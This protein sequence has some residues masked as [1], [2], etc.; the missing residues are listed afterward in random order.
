MKMIR[1]LASTRIIF[2]VTFLLLVIS[3][4]GVTLGATPGPFALSE[5]SSGQNTAT[6][7]SG[8]YLEAKA[9]WEGVGRV[10]G[11]VPVS[12][13]VKNNGPAFKGRVEVVVSTRVLPYQVAVPVI[14]YG[15]EISLPPGGQKRV[16]QHVPLERMG[17]NGFLEVRL[18]KAGTEEVLAQV[19][20]ALKVYG[21]DTVLAGVLSER[22]DQVFEFLENIQLGKDQRG[23]PLYPRVLKISRELLPEQPGVFDTFSVLLV[24]GFDPSSL[25]QRQRESLLDW[26]E[27]GGV[28]VVTVGNR[29]DN[30]ADLL[31]LS[32]PPVTVTKTVT[33]L[34]VEEL[35]GYTLRE[36]HARPFTVAVLKGSTGEGVGKTTAGPVAWSTRVGRGVL[37]V[38]GIDPGVEPMLTW[39]HKEDFWRGLLKPHLSFTPEVTKERY[40]LSAREGSLDGAL[41]QAINLLPPQLAPS[42]LNVAGL[43]LGYIL[44]VGLVNHL[45]LA[46]LDRREWMWVTV[47]VLA[48]VVIVVIYAWGFVGS[49][50]NVIA[51]YASIIELDREGQLVQA[52]SAVGIYAPTRPWQEITLSKQVQLNLE[53]AYDGYRDDRYGFP[54]RQEREVPVRVVYGEGTRVSF[55]PD[56]RWGLRRITFSR[57]DLQPGRIV[58]HLHVNNLVLQ[59]EIMNDTRYKIDEGAVVWGNKFVKIGPLNPGEKTT[60]SLDLGTP[61]PGRSYE[62]LNVIYRMYGRSPYY[63]PAQQRQPVNPEDPRRR[64]VLERFLGIQVAPDFGGLPFMF[65]GWASEPPGDLE[66]DTGGGMTTH[67]TLL[68][69]PLTLDFPAGPY[70]LPAQLLRGRLSQI[71]VR[72]GWGSEKDEY[73]LEQGQMVFEFSIPVLELET[74]NKITLHFEV[75]ATQGQEGFRDRKEGGGLV[76]GTL[77]VY[78]WVTGKWEEL[79][80][81]RMTIF[82]RPKAYLSSAGLFRLRV[83]RPEDKG[84]LRFRVP[85]LELEG[86]AR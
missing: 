9:G 42:W 69:Q 52:G 47:P 26:L 12:I 78:N 10:S 49:G 60:V 43:F 48:L 58:S 73:V 20:P 34:E 15:E 13:Y 80:A 64:Q 24:R 77:Q 65:L 2:I 85:S 84:Q 39:P 14:A 54:I 32:A 70:H 76:D 81:R 30:L 22:E 83:W 72:G 35:G 27:Q 40:Y 16:V 5:E 33:V 55:G 68:V 82:D 31:P 11:W 51:N 19:R 66:I 3:A 63:G 29:D 62:T 71:E 17:L 7:T 61:E 57:E 23:L 50:R 67:L 79:A 56:T 36:P 86:S 59:G 28:L 45:V 6:S 44:L 41:F 4:P 37:L 74:I 38:L 75:L 46:R 1:P 21:Q 8:F 18:I 53:T 25:T